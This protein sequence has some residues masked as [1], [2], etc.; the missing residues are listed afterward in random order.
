MLK[1]LKNLFVYKKPSEHG[2]R[3][4]EDAQESESWN[5]Y[6]GKTSNLQDK[7][8]SNNSQ[9]NRKRTKTGILKGIQ[10]NI[11][12]MKTRRIRKDKIT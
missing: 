5:S 7:S 3:F 1:G 8:E 6:R 2:F 12:L 11:I 9:E 10:E 4:P